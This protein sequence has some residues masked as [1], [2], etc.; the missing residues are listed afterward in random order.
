M[1]LD[2]LAAF[3]RGVSFSGNIVYSS[4]Q[5]DVTYA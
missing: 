4:Q 2:A 3:R 1:L 5:T